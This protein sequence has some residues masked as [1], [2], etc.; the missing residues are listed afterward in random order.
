MTYEQDFLKDFEAWV[1]QQIMINKVAMDQAHHI[2]KEDKDKQAE[3]AFIRYESK[4]DA[5]QFLKGKFANYHAKKN[6]HDLPEDL[7]GKRTY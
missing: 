5:Y 2:W 7:L 1:D 6:F 3:D 4:Q